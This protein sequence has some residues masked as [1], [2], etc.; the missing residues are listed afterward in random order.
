MALSVGAILHRD[1]SDLLQG[2][3]RYEF[4]YIIDRRSIEGVRNFV[5]Q[6]CEPDPHCKGSSPRYEV[7]TLQLDTPF[8]DLGLAKERDALNRFKLRVRAYSP[9]NENEIKLEVKEKLNDRY[10]KLKSRLRPGEFDAGFL[11]DAQVTPPNLL[12]QDVRAYLTFVRL[13][14]EIS[15]RPAMLIRYERESY[16]SVID[17]YARVTLDGRLRYATTD[18]WELDPGAVKW[19]CMDTSTALRDTRGSAILELKTLQ[20][21]PVW[22]TELIERFALDRVGFCK[23]S[24][25]LRLE[26]LFRGFTYSDASDNCTY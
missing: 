8:H 4:K 12:P 10:F 13:V 3:G 7:T 23:Y 25:A 1:S 15:A 17:D 26:S 16:N 5:R 6:F 24:T 22:M 21:M 2:V 20:A 19:R 18:R 14:R 11:L 9:W